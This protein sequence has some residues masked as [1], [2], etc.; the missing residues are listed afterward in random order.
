VD[1]QQPGARSEDQT[2]AG[3]DDHTALSAQ[4]R[5]AERLV[6]ACFAVS[7]AAGVGLFVLYFRGGQTQLEGML[8]AV[9]MGGLGI[10]IGIWGLRLLGGGEEVEERH[11]LASEPGAEEAFEEALSEEVGPFIRRR[12]VLVRALVGAGG[13][14]GLALLLPVL[15]LG[16]AP[17]RSLKQT[18]WRRGLQLVDENGTALTLQ[19]LPED[20][21]LTVYPQGAVGRADSQALLI[22]VPKGLLELP[23][24]RMAAV[25]D[26]SY[27]AYS[28]LCTHAGCPV[29]LYR[30]QQ[31]TLLCPCHQSQFDVLD[32][33]KPFFGPAAAPLPQLPLGVDANGFLVA[34]GDFY[35]PVG[36]A[37]WDR[38]KT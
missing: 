5:R 1:S 7:S 24:E 36:P 27:V 13:A 23:P 2:A 29:G 18:G 25:P 31:R 26:G 30:A 14:I 3:R 33:G 32:G 28:K 37:F 6:L 8:W 9:A 21:F 20:G 11:E 19:S 12:S 15:S 10:G 22:R 17:G 38:D 4:Q 34:L 16:P 35:E